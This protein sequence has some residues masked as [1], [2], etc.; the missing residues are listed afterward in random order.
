MN[1]NPCCLLNRYIETHNFCASGKSIRN[2]RMHP[3]RDL[4]TDADYGGKE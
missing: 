2:G 1:G 3:K 4:E